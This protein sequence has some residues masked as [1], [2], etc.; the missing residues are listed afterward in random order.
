VGDRTTVTLTFLQSQQ[1]EA[2]KH[3]DQVA[4]GAEIVDDLAH[5]V[6]YDVN[7]GNLE[8]LDD[9][10]AAGIAYDSTWDSGSGFTSGTKSCRFMPDGTAVIKEIYES[11]NNPNLGSL[12]SRIDDLLALRQFVLEH[13]Q[14][15]SVLP[16]DN[17]EE[18]GQRY[19][20]KQLISPT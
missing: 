4:S 18:Y 15:V 9:L 5:H 6:F 12:M 7:Y 19:R 14:S 8:F 13:H 2:L 17:Q 16:W 10:Q 20:T 3:F 1:E 11:E